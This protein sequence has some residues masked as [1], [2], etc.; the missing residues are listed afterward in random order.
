M[1]ADLLS[2]PKIL[3]RLLEIHAAR[4]AFALEE[5]ELLTQLQKPKKDTVKPVPLTFGKN[6]ITWGDG[7]ALAI[8]GKGYKLVKALYEANKMRLKRET[9]GVIVW[10]CDLVRQNTFLLFFHWL[11][12]KLERARFPYRL[13]PIKSKEK[14][15]TV[16][17]KAKGKPVKK[18]IQS[19]IIGAKL[20]IR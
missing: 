9:L 8:K 18:R 10:N 11:S 16:E 2:T 13:I 7:Q 1:T 12:E 15:K 19:E 5:A 4:K 3:D 17:H 6:V 20:D 14:I